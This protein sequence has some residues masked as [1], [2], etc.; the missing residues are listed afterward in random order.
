MQVAL[1]GASSNECFTKVEVEGCLDCQ[2]NK[3]NGRVLQYILPYTWYE[4]WLFSFSSV[5]NAIV[6]RKKMNELR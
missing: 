6:K 5:I 2:V 4:L 3:L 1:P